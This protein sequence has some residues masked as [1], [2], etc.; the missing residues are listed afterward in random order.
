MTEVLA[1]DSMQFAES[2]RT[3]DDN[4]FL[5][6][7]GCAITKEQVAPY[8]GR[9][10][11][12]WQRL[13]LNPDSIYKLYRPAAEIKKAVESCN[14]IPI[15]LEHHEDLADAPAKETRI[16]STG[17][18]GEF[19]APY[20]VNS[21]HF[22]DAN[23]IKR[24]QDG[25]MRELSLCYRYEPVAKH[26]TFNGEDYDLVMTN[27]SCNHV[28]LVERGRAGHDV[29]VKDS[30]PEGLKTVGESKDSAQN[31]N[32]NAVDGVITTKKEENAMDSE[33]LKLF[34]DEL[35]KAGIDG[36][37]AK[38]TIEEII[39]ERTA[40]PVKAEEE[41]KEEVKTED[42]NPVDAKNE[43]S[44]VKDKDVVGVEEVTAEDQ[45]I[46]DALKECGLDEEPEEVQK[47]FAEGVKYGEKLEKTEPKKLDSEHESEGEK[48]ALGE[49]DD[50]L[51][52]KIAAIVE[53]K[54]AERF[55][56]AE[57]AAPVLGKV[58]AMGFD[59]A[60][61]IY[62]AAC[63]KIGVTIKDMSDNECRA[64]YRAMSAVKA[65][66]TTMAKDSAT[67]DVKDPIRDKLNKVKTSF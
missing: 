18:D 14:G 15:Q 30:E 53:A 21:L 3:I 57:E 6:V 66:N 55:K 48:K 32:S 49:D 34:I 37:K 17:T 1:Y 59:S 33:K 4:G 27:I 39:K 47:A 7:T 13:G 50:D 54:V 22:T 40:E 5:H 19:K 52:D 29:F 28:A 41:V 44:E 10:I 25:S 61:S 60:G 67:T 58:N 2:A 8:F 23:A 12:N 38:T 11:P 16:G 42:E 65:R 9:E 31:T 26:G 63:Q 56:A 36:E 62:R 20:L 45:L 24:I 51:T 35:V 43:D 64:V 46:K